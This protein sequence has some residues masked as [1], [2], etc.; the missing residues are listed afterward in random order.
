MKNELPVVVLCTVYPECFLAKQKHLFDWSLLELTELQNK[1]IR[2][3]SI[4]N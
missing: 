3:F 1:S 2:Q 4:K